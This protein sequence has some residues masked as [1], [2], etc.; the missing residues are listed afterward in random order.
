VTTNSL[1]ERA[2]KN[3][4]TAKEIHD[5]AVEKKIRVVEPFAG[6][7]DGKG[8]TVLGPTRD[9][10]Q[11]LLANFKF[12][13]GTDTATSQSR[14]AELMKQFG[15]KVV[16]WVPESW[17]S[18]TLKEPKQ[19]A[20]SAENNSSVIFILKTDERK[21]LF[22][23]DAGVPALTVAAD[24]ALA[25]NIGLD[26]I[27]FFQVPHHGSRRNL[28]PTILNRMFGN[29]RQTDAKDWSA[30][31]SAAKDGAPKHP[32]KRVTNALRRRGAAVQV[33]A[34]KGVLY[35]FNAPDRGWT[36]LEPLP[37]YEQVEDDD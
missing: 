3:L 31:I 20:T 16:S 1:R 4:S 32:N 18:E 33:T 8:I 9:Y 10:Y 25:E 28:G 17:W 2:K 23:G 34:G 37:F 5:L 19:D 36:W 7:G 30:C 29:V 27:N 14:L 12:M 11:Q 35:R 13:P 22:A 21:L 6:V 24:F 26:G 15:E